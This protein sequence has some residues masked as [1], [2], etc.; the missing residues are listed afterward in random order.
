MPA[1]YDLNHSKY[2][3]QKITNGWK[4]KNLNNNTKL[5]KV[6]NNDNKKNNEKEKKKNKQNTATNTQ[7]AVEELEPDTERRLLAMNSTV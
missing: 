7:H 2:T 1:A 6:R 4:K 5:W 3:L